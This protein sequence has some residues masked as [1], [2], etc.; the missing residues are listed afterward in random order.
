MPSAAEHLRAR[1]R[2]IASTA[3]AEAAR[4]VVEGRRLLVLDPVALGRVEEGDALGARAARARRPRRGDQVA[5]PLAAH[6]VGR[7]Q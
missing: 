1:G 7:R 6:P 5:R 3:R 4:R 2:A